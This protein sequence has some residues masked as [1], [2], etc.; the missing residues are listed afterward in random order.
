[1]QK[2]PLQTDCV[3]ESLDFQQ[4][5]EYLKGQLAQINYMIYE[6]N[7]EFC[8]V[9]KGRS[10]SVDD[11]ALKNFV[12]NGFKTRERHHVT[13]DHSNQL[14]DNLRRED[15]DHDS[16]EEQ[17]NSIFKDDE[18]EKTLID[19][20][21]IVSSNR[22]DS[23]KLELEVCE[24]KCEKIPEE[25]QA[26]N[27]QIVILKE[28]RDDDVEVVIEVSQSSSSSSSSVLSSSTI[29]KVVEESNAFEKFFKSFNTTLNSDEVKKQNAENYNK[30]V[31]L[32]KK[33][34]QK[35]SIASNEGGLIITQNSPKPKVA[36]ELFKQESSSTQIPPPPPPLPQ[37]NPVITIST[38]SIT[39]KVVEEDE[40]IIEDEKK[41]GPL[42]S[43]QLVDT[44]STDLI[45][46]LLK[47]DSKKN[48]I[49]KQEHHS[50]QTWV[51]Y[52]LVIK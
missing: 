18:L 15:G 27:G 7:S 41:E 5:C 48:D 11:E 46:L 30:I 9:N 42:I 31:D 8:S 35:Q 19:S 1:V 34:N 47:I 49:N 37:P 40:N 52:L 28:K 24:K 22:D 32:L 20:S 23:D 16:Y 6:R 33:S 43:K 50:I 2:P 39:K 36:T 29:T 21:P 38:S 14:E 10:K 3:N 12:Q 26:L 17:E 44:S 25:Q 13:V 45:K 4:T 51:I